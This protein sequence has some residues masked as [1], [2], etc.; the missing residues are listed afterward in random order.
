MSL[1]PRNP[2]APPRLTATALAA[3]MARGDIR[4]AFQPKV[5]LAD[6]TLIGVEAL[7]RWTDPALGAVPP[8]RF[9]P[10][11]E[12]HELI[13]ALTMAVLRESL[14]AA[15]LLRCH[16]PEATVAVNISP[17]LL[18]DPALPDAITALLDAAGLPAGALVA[19]I[20][21]GRP[22]ADPAR[23][24]A[25]LAELRA[26][27]IGCAM[28]DFGTG[29][30]TLPALLRMPFT[31][32]KIDRSFV[33]RIIDLPE[34]NRLVRATI[35]LGQSLGLRVVAEGIENAAVAALLRE[36]GCDAGQGYH[37]G[38]AMPV[39]AV[40]DRWPGPARGATCANPLS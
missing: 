9:I 16:H 14:A 20:T 23:A 22:F 39:A 19:E 18:D 40:L 33:A 11:A 26:R 21:E 8:D 17:V 37:F 7:A 1:S 34:A 2:A 36:A 6:A 31:E 35:T 3:A 25:V 32:L 12:R 4:V 27:G 13:G 10:L 29:Y 30:A 15:R 38:R 28:D 24:A 5:A